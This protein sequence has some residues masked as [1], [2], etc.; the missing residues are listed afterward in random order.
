MNRL[1][2]WIIPFLEWRRRLQRHRRAGEVYEFAGD[3]ERAIS[4]Y[5][6]VLN[7]KPR[8]LESR[9]ALGRC[10]LR[11][12]S[13][14][15]ADLHIAAV[16][17]AEKNHAEGNLYAG[18]LRFYRNDLDTAKMHLERVVVGRTTDAKK[19]SMA[20]EYLGEIAL[21]QGNYENAIEYLEQAVV[22]CPA[23]VK[24]ERRWVLLAEAYHAI[25]DGQQAI[26]SLRTALTHN[27][28]S[29][30]AWNDLGVL[31]W[32]HGKKREARICLETAVHL[33]PDYQDAKRNLLAVSQT[34]LRAP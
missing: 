26:I 20:Q 28:E 2:V 9:L 10:Y 12:L 19:I 30:R 1:A 4:C 32:S 14:H 7:R 13:F 33:N 24:T 15:Q 25:G 34:E 6:E 31:L 22:L 29:D 16:L 21:Q 11:L 27:P 5:Q 17:K 23:T 18:I 8:D 3:S